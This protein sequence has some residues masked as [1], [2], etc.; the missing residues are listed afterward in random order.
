MKSKNHIFIKL[1]FVILII[2]FLSSCERKDNPIIQSNNSNGLQHFISEKIGYYNDGI[3][4][5]VT[6]D[7]GKTWKLDNYNDA[8]GSDIRYWTFLETGQGY[9]LTRDHRIIKNNF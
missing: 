8:Q 2:P 9:A 7:G 1:F 3:T 5:Y 6:N 4:V